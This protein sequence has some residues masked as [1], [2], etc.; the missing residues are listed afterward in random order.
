M[1]CHQYRFI[2]R[3]FQCPYLLVFLFDG[4]MTIH[5]MTSA[6]LKTISHKIMWCYWSLQVDVDL[7]KQ[8]AE[9]PDEND[10][11]LRKKLWLRIGKNLYRSHFQGWLRLKFISCSLPCCYINRTY[12]GASLIRTPPFPDWISGSVSRFLLRNGDWFANRFPDK[13]GPDK[14]GSTVSPFSSP[15]CNANN[16]Y[17]P[18]S[19]HVVMPTW[20]ISPQLAMLWKR[21]KMFGELWNSSM[22]VICWKLKIFCHFFL[23]L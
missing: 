18:L 11:D 8:Q 1:L 13:W 17:L 10:L 19:R 15:C 20:F 22:I 3:I 2:I 7:A 5:I 6:L 16:I 14:W 23:I 9:K 12:S 21:K 4:Y